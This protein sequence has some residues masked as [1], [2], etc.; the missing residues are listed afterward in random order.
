MIGMSTKNIIWRLVLI[1][2]VYAQDFFGLGVHYGVTCLSLKTR[3]NVIKQ[4]DYQAALFLISKLLAWNV[5]I[6]KRNNLAKGSKN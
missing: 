2:F 1:N 4:F 6:G 3:P 5:C